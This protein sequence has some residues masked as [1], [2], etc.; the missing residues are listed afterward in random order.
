VLFVRPRLVK[1]GGNCDQGDIRDDLSVSV[2][3]LSRSE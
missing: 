1:S 3:A 2:I